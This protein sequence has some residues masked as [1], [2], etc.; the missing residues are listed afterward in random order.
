MATRMRAPIVRR[1]SLPLT[2]QDERDLALIRESPAHRHA[3]AQVSGAPDDAELSE[4]AVLHSVFEAG[5]GVIHEAA[6]EAGYAELAQAWEGSRDQARRRR[7]GW[8]D[9]L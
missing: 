5:L 1:P 7:P 6:L 4:A 2:E 8:A 9:E 3:L